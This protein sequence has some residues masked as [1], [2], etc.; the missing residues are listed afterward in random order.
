D[1]SVNAN[2]KEKVEIV[3][4][5]GN[6]TGSFVEPVD[7]AKV[8]KAKGVRI[9]VIAMGDPQTVGEVALDME[10]INRVAQESGG[11]SFEV[12]NRDELTKAYAQIGEL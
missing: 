1:S 12:L 9:H 8:A 7:A 3:L 11:E 2:E 6:D 5:D 4:T 10:T